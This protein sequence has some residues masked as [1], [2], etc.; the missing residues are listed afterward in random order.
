MISNTP[1]ILGLNTIF[2]SIDYK[3]FT[4]DEFRSSVSFMDYDAIVIDTSYLANDYTE[5]YPP[6]FEGKRMISK[7]ESRL[8]VEEFSRT[9]TQIIDFLKQGKNVFVLLG[10]NE[11]C[12]IHTGKTEY[13]GTG[14]NARGTNIV[15][16]FD[17]F[18]F[19]PIAIN[20]TMVSGE[21]F[22]ISCQPPY[23][24]FFQA[25]KDMVYY[26][27]YFEAPKKSSL[28]TLSNSDKSIS[29]VFEYEKG[30]IIILPYPYDEGYFDTEK[31]WK[32]CAKKFLD[33]L[34]ELNRSLC[35]ESNSYELPLWSNNVKL[36][37]EEDEENKLEQEM[38]KLQSIQDKIQKRR[39]EIKSIQKKKILITASGTP[40]EEVVQ[41]TL[42]EIGFTLSETEVGRSDIIASYN[43]TDIVAEIK[44]VSKS[45]AEKHA[46][47]LEKWVAQFIE[48]K[49]HAPK[50]ILIVNGYC[51]IPLTER[52][53]DVFPNQMLKYCE[54]RG[55]A[56]VT[57][58]QLLC[59]YIEI[60]KNPAC[61]EERIAELLSCVGK[62]QR[63]DDYEKYIQLIG[64]EESKE[65]E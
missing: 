9:K 27:A 29:A 47:Q 45:A 20:P 35:I 57:T 23:S 15:T 24:T 36:L 64:K 63:Y 49:E 16:I 17:T 11:N 43:G 32:K 8:M 18:S 2:G 14:K 50:P 60:K 58:T 21:K 39:K 3:G 12:Y 10:A 1:S 5:D 42:Q 65:N 34:F 40:L 30:K 46:A 55:H 52:V 62:F 22:N 7:N 61:A 6:T 33:A 19:L 53:E 25:T 13:S 59:L 28:L 41:E 48:E 37:N 51:D 54:A 44:G 31:E 26:D 38:K 4:H 56:L